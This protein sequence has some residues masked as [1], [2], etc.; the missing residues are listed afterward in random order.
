MKS[1]LTLTLGQEIFYASFFITKER[2][3][4]MKTITL[5]L[6][7]LSCQHCVK[8]VK[9]T[10]E[11][12]EGVESAEVNLTEAVV[13]TD[14]APQTLINAIVDAGYQAELLDPVAK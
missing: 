12:I 10:L 4:K 8:A 5:K 13:Q 6:A 3:K 7:D 1:F 14:V 9:K 11:G 2:G